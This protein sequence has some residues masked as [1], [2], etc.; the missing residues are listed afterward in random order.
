VSE[1]EKGGLGI[2]VLDSLVFSLSVTLTVTVG[3]VGQRKKTGTREGSWLLR[4]LLRAWFAGRSGR[5][6]I[7]DTE[8]NTVSFAEC[9]TSA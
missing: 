9:G 3:L 8:C 1:R 2:Q 5:P 4:S 6:C 7:G